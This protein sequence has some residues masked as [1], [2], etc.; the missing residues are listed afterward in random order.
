MVKS[1]ARSERAANNKLK[2]RAT[3]ASDAAVDAH[4]VLHQVGCGQLALAAEA[5]V[6]QF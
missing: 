4:N 3:I 2:T 6:V 5:V 1:V